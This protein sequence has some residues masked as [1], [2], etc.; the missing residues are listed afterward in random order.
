M[1]TVFKDMVSSGHLGIMERQSQITVVTTQTGVG[2]VQA[3]VGAVQTG[4]QCG[5]GTVQTG[6]GTGIVVA[7]GRVR[8]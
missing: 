6:A 5:V 1:A 7:R 8:S 2:M 4:V 3:G